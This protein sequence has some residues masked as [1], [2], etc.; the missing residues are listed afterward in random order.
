[1]NEEEGGEIEGRESQLIDIF[2]KQVEEEEIMEERKGKK[3]LCTP[4]CPTTCIVERNTRRLYGM[5][6]Q[7]CLIT[8]QKIKNLITKIR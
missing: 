5:K 4:I 2:E 1:M 6:I 7:V 8:Y 3:E